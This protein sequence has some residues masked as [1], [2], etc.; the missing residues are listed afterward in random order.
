MGDEGEEGARS[1]E[2]EDPP[3]SE[4]KRLTTKCVPTPSPTKCVIPNNASYSLSSV[5]P[6]LSPALW[7]TRIQKLDS[8]SD[9]RARASLRYESMRR[10]AVIPPELRLR[11]SIL[12]CADLRAWIGVD[13]GVYL[14]VV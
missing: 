5:P 1:D 7:E 3:R 2:D 4:K 8:F 14:C 6:K 13:G 12:E 10:S 9:D 11:I